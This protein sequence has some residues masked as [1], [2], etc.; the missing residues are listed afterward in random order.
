M[1]SEISARTRLSLGALGS[2]S[3][4]AGGVASFMS[5]NGA[6]AAGLIA[7]GVICAALALIGRWPTRIAMSGSRSRG[8][9]LGRPSRLSL[10]SQKRA[11]MLA[12][13]LRS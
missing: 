13:R 11:M 8:R 1:S 10:R 3:W 12:L 4:A 9:R 5:D 7:A 2:I 6:G